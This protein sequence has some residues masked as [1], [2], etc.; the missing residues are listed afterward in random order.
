MA[1]DRPRY[2]PVEFHVWKGSE[3]S[4]HRVREDDI[5]TDPRHHNADAS[6]EDTALEKS[7]RQAVWVSEL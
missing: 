2:P 7:R 5:L 6:C 4:Q 3:A 1:E